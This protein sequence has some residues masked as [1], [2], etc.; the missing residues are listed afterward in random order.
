[1]NFKIADLRDKQVLS[2]KDASV[3][4][5]VS[6]VEFDSDSGKLVSIIVTGKSRGISLL[7]SREDIII[8]WEKIEVIGND[9]ILV[10]FEGVLPQNKKRR[11]VLNGLFYGD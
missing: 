5:Y 10:G 1:M 6:D 11:S 9:S 8:P 4:G 2:I 7:S 3:L